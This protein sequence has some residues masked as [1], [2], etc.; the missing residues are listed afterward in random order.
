MVPILEMSQSLLSFSD[1]TSFKTSPSP[2][3]EGIRIRPVVLKEFVDALG[4]L[5]GRSRLETCFCLL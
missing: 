2:G 5:Q 4:T 3:E 1:S